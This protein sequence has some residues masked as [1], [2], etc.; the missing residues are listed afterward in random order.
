MLSNMN[1]DYFLPTR[2][3]FGPG[4]LKKLHEQPLPGRKALL[5]I[6]NGKSTRANGYLDGVENELKLAGVEFEVFDQ[7]QPNPTN[8]NV[9]AG[10]ALARQEDCDFVI[11]LGG[12][13]CLDACKAIA[14]MATN[15]GNFWDYIRGGSGK[16]RALQ[17]KPLPVV[18]ISTTAGTGSETDAWAV[19]SNEQAS[20]K[21]GF[22]SEA[23][24]PCLSI[25]DP[26]MML[27]VPPDFT[28]YQGF[29]AFFHNAEGY[30]SKAG[31]LFTDMC[32]LTGIENISRNL[33]RTV[34]DG[35]DLEARTRVAFGNTLA[36][37]VMTVGSTTSQ[38]SFEHALSASHPKLPHGAG[39]IM[40]SR[41]FFT[42]QA[43]SGACDQ[44]L[45]NMA[46]AM[47]RADASK[48][49]DFVEA[50]VELQ[51]ACGVADLRMSDYGIKKS[52][53]AQ[54]AKDARR[55]MGLLFEM[56]PSP[57]SDEAGAE[58]LEKSFK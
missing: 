20:E 13:S 6:S 4:R 22:G 46:K 34:E 36:G 57:I 7:I 21:I 14:A 24:L 29:D 16:G 48:P 42:F 44:R 47:G 37:Y 43:R 1:F 25:V 53:L 54:Y 50:L 31:N 15:S 52:D 11:G 30:I 51:K 23:T 8:D 32:A 33:P 10:A 2:L 17:E 18:C 40:I 58:I 19:I 38:H 55:T 45:V 28:A 12:G 41:A 56:D 3:L 5:V 39:L 35:N 27:S 49:M 26:E 9:M